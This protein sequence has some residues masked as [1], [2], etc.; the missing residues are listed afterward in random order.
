MRTKN[1]K[2]AN[3]STNIKDVINNN[4]LKG[5]KGWNIDLPL[6]DGL[7]LNFGVFVDDFFDGFWAA[8][9]V[10][11]RALAVQAVVDG[12]ATYLAIGFELMKVPVKNYL[13]N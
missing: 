10:N 7:H 6:I 2:N 12:R 1:A 8:A 5:R 13:S 9:A 11:C 3:T 4:H